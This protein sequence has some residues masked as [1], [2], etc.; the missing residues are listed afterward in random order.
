MIECPECGKKSVSFCQDKIV[1]YYTSLTTNGIIKVS[2]KVISS[3]ELD[4]CWLECSNCNAT[5][6]DNDVLAEMFDSIS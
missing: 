1:T 3:N 5:S 4:N 6:E 2:N